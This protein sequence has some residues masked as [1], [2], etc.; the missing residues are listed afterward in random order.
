MKVPPTNEWLPEL[1]SMD[2]FVTVLT[3]IPSPY[4]VELFDALHRSQTVQIRVVY[5]QRN[6]PARHWKNQRL[7]HEHLFLEDGTTA[8]HLAEDWVDRAELFVASWYADRCARVLISRRADSNR[9]WVF[10]GERPGASRWRLLGRLRRGWY[11][12]PLRQSNAPIWGI[13]QWGIEGWQEEFGLQ[14]EYVNLPYFSDVSRFASRTNVSARSTGG[15]RFLYSGSLI[16]RKGVD[17]LADAF[18]RLA[19]EY[20]DASLEFVGAG[21][22]EQCLRT[23]LAPLGNR[24]RFTGFV[25]WADLPAAYQRADVL[26]APSR[27]DGWGL[28]VPEGLAAGLPVIATDRMGSAKDLIRHGVNGWIVKAG[29][30]ESLRSAIGAACQLTPAQ[31]H[32][33]STAACNSVRHHQLQD[34]VERFLAAS[35][36]AIGARP[37]SEACAAS[38]G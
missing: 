25:S 2:S 1:I 26:I 24:V 31:L 32:E 4:Q 3:Q 11:L 36:S 28:I 17:L 10:W 23:K 13:G 21:V 22:L 19:S 16:E 37:R 6:D 7:L 38:P 27:Y 29:L 5:V 35:A 15:V 20:R 14:R 30:E 8:V 18:A 9:P 34:G 12:R 33:M